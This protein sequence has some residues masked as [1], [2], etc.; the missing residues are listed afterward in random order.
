MTKEKFYNLMSRPFELT[1]EDN[2]AVNNALNKYPYFQTARILS[3][4]GTKIYNESSY[5]STL[6]KVAAHAADRSLL[7]DYTH[8]KTFLEKNSKKGHKISRVKNTEEKQRE[9]AQDPTKIERISHHT[10]SKWLLLSDS[11]TKKDLHKKTSQQLAIDRFIQLNPKL[12]V[13]KNIQE[14]YNIP[15]HSITENQ[16]LMTE[17]LANLYVEQ[18]KYTKA[19]QAFKILGLKYPKKSGYFAD[20]IKEI[21]HLEENKL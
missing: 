12:S 1:K 21:K 20:K 3:L 16:N 9:I 11:N 7:F 14:K 19:R 18:K 5:Y 17:T 10:F 8:H 4:R 2:T 15:L 13:P 6:K